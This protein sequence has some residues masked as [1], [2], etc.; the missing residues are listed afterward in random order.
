M[1]STWRWRGFEYCIKLYWKNVVLFLMDVNEIKITRL[2]W[3]RMTFWKQRIPLWLVFEPT[4]V[5]TKYIL[6]TFSILQHVSAYHA[7]HH[8]EFFVPVFITLSNGP[9]WNRFNEITVMHLVMSVFCITEHTICSLADLNEDESRQ[10][11]RHNG[12]EKLQRT[13][14]AEWLQYSP[15][16]CTEDSSPLSWT[17]M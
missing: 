13:D 17:L 5:C 7:C 14:G 10:S 3:K 15:F 12:R 11:P 4:F 9:L 2:P 1:I 8:Q 16:R 6:Y